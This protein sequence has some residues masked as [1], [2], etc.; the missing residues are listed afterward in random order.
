MGIAVNEDQ[1][2]L[3]TLDETIL[4]SQNKELAN[5]YPNAS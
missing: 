5:K 2:A 4:F 1:M 3:A